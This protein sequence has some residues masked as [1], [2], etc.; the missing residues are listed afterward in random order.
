MTAKHMLC[1]SAV[2]LCLLALSVNGRADDIHSDDP[3]KS[4]VINVET[5]AEGPALELDI[6]E[7]VEVPPFELVETEAVSSP[8]EIEVDPDE[9]YALAHLICGEAQSCSRE[10]QVAVG[11]VVLNR[12][13]HPAYPDTIEGV[14]FQ[15]RQYACT[16]DGNYYRD[17]TPTNWEVAE[18]LLREGSQIP[19]NVI[20]QAQFK[21]GNFT[22]RRIENE[23]FCG[24]N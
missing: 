9:L 1:A 14:I 2:A 21:Q 11:S 10:L 12:V 19:S 6:P 5:E 7:T 23:Y 15:K 3:E 16:W 13:A 22:W 4:V 17:P 8:P 18:M 20:F 24:V